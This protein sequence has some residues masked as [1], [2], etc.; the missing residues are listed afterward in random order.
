MQRRSVLHDPNS[1]VPGCA[2]PDPVMAC[3]TAC[4]SHKCPL[5]APPPESP[6]KV[7]HAP[8]PLPFHTLCMFPNPSLLLLNESAW[9][10][11]GTQE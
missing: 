5:A 4:V 6:S 9:I 7:R 3:I 10:L 11:H 8:G 1:M 2:R